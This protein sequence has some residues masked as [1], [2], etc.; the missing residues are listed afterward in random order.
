MILPPSPS[1]TH[2]SLVVLL[3][4]QGLGGDGRRMLIVPPLPDLLMLNDMPILITLLVTVME[5]HVSHLKVS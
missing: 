5:E 2:W 3:S 4:H 1:D